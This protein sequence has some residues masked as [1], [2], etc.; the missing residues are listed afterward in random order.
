MPILRKS[1]ILRAF[2]LYEE[3]LFY[4]VLKLMGMY[5]EA[6]P[7]NLR[8]PTTPSTKRYSFLTS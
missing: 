7:I 1:N 2:S 4:F 6:M 3:N 5:G 8:I